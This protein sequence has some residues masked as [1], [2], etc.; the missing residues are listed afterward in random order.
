MRTRNQFCALRSVENALF[1]ARHTHVHSVRISLVTCVCRCSESALKVNKYWSSPALTEPCW[2]QNPR[3]AYEK[4]VEL[5]AHRP[6]KQ[7]NAQS[8]QGAALLAQARARGIIKSSDF[9]SSFQAV[10]IAL[11]MSENHND[12]IVTELQSDPTS[13]LHP[14]FKTV[15][16]GKWNCGWEKSFSCVHMQTYQ[17]TRIYFF[18]NQQSRK[19]AAMPACSLLTYLI[20][21]FS[22]VAMC[23][24][25]HNICNAASNMAPRFEIRR[26]Y[27]NLVNPDEVL[28]VCFTSMR[29]IT[30][31][32]QRCGYCSYLSTVHEHYTSGSR[33]SHRA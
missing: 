23:S 4:N 8:K 31:S 19:P 7:H 26:W 11:T 30:K 13:C 2:A 27:T 18:W 33:N 5:C 16:D 32:L 25:A 9:I 14:W 10:S 6:R 21:M 20:F 1:V 28:N 15:L 22:Y 12:N 29:C 17:F 3:T 24:L